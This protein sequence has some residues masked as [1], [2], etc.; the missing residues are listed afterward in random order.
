M[1]KNVIE[2]SA[3]SWKAIKFI[4]FKGLETSKMIGNHRAKEISHGKLNF[5]NPGSSPTSCYL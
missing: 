4:S 3:L 2:D 1:K 5:A